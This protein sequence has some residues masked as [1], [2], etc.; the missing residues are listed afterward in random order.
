MK[1]W[2]K[3]NHKSG[4]M[5]KASRSRY[6]AILDAK[7]ALYIKEVSKD[8]IPLSKQLERFKSTLR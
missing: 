1:D 3:S 4:T 8:I 7:Y 6:N 5:E 2:V